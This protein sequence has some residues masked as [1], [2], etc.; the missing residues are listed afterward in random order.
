LKNKTSRW[1]KAAAEKVTEIIQHAGLPGLA[2]CRL[3]EGVQAPDAPFGLFQDWQ[4]ITNSI[5][6]GGPFVAETA[7]GCLVLHIAG[8]ICR[9]AH[10]RKL[11]DLEKLFHALLLSASG[12]LLPA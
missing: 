11:K 6:C 3:G 12:E 1:L 7:N 8:T 5:F 2:S 10:N 9:E 4:E